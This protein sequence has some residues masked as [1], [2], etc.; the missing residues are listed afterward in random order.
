MPSTVHSIVM[1]TTPLQ[2][3][4]TVLSGQWDTHN[5][6]QE[7][8]SGEG[9]GRQNF[10]GVIGIHLYDAALKMIPAPEEFTG[11]TTVTTNPQPLIKAAQ[12][13]ESDVAGHCQIIKNEV[14]ANGTSEQTPMG[15]EVP[16]HNSDP[17]LQTLY[18]KCGAQFTLSA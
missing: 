12:Q 18:R 10:I 9:T 4:S 5:R 3:G 2:T 1:L 6:T 14:W 7:P 17:R 8:S 16:P 13:Q 11:S 15:E